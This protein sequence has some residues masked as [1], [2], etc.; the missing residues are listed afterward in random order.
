[1]VPKADSQ[2]SVTDFEVHIVRF[3]GGLPMRFIP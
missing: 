1:V 3:Y 2:E